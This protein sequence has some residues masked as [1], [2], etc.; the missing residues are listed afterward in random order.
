MRLFLNLQALI[1]T[2][3]GLISGSRAMRFFGAVPISIQ[4]RGGLISGSNPES[5][6][7]FSL[8]YTTCKALQC[9]NLDSDEGRAMQGRCLPDA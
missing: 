4:T 9:P 1:Q 5:I 8:S 6:I 3:D 2:Q 7:I